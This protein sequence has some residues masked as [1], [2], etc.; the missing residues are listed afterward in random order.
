[1]L[2]L[3]GAWTYTDVLADLARG[4]GQSVAVRLM[5]A[6]ALLLGA[7]TGGFAAG[8]WTTTLPSAAGLLRSFTGGLLMGWGSLLIPGGNDGLILLGMPMLWPYAWASIA[9]LCA[10]I[11]GAMWIQRLCLPQ[12][13]APGGR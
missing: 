2:L 6:A 1:M 10:A 5:L 7:L 12:A 11:A 13:R 8:R 3:A 4:M 9:T